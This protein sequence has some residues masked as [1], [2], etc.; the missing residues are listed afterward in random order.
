MLGSREAVKL[1]TQWWTPKDESR[2]AELE[3]CKK[4][5][6]EVFG[7]RVYLDGSG[8]SLTF[9]QL[10]SEAKDGEVVVVANTDVWFDES[11]SILE[12][13]VRGNV[14]AALTRWN[15]RSGPNM[16]GWTVPTLG[17]GP[18]DFHDILF[19]SGTQDAWAFVGSEEM[20]DSLDIPL[21]VLGCDQAIVSWAVS[22]G[23]FVINPALS[24]KCWHQHAAR[25]EAGSEWVK[26]IYGYPQL[27]T[28]E[29]TGV[30]ATHGWTGDGEKK[31]GLIK[32]QRSH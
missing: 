26:G 27:T 12:R 28:E 11:I 30:V 31:W 21:G 14:F 8:G 9:K 24:V 16:S 32:C 18:A 7:E 23:M 19:F 25:A 20:R 22:K 15:N 5:N 3:F 2:L 1:I 29:V 4:K 10:F 17:A 6:A 13:L